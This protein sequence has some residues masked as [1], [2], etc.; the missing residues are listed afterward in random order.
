MDGGFIVRLAYIVNI[1]NHT[2][3]FVLEVDA[4]SGDVIPGCMVRGRKNPLHFGLGKRLR[5]VRRQRDI[6]GKPLSIAANLAAT[7]VL[8]IEAEASVPSIDAVAKLATVLHVSPG[9]LAYGID[10]QVRLV[11]S[12]P[13]TTLA[14][15][16]R[17]VREL[18]GLSLNA[19]AKVSGV[20]RTTIGYLEAETTTPSVATVELLAHAL[21]VPAPWLAYGEGH[22]LVG[23]EKPRE[24][25]LVTISS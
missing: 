21:G 22:A 15:R 19:L 12:E 16:L 9:Y 8:R 7:A 11:S 13:P 4:P 24:S 17:Q 20:A 23:A 10:S 5:A 3:P 25:D 2:E 18:R 14:E 6:G 1:S